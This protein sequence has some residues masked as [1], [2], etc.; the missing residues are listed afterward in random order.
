MRRIPLRLLSVG[1]ALPALLLA[2]CGSSSSASKSSSSSSPSSSTA[3]TPKTV[4]ASAVTPMSDISVNTAKPKAPAIKLAKQPFQVNKTTVKTLTKGTGRQVTTKD[5][6]YVDYVAVNGKNG[7]QLVNSFSAK[8][9]PV[10]LADK[11]QFPG[12]VTALKGAT[13]GSTMEVAIPPADGFGGAGNKQLGITNADT[14][15]FYMKVEDARAPLTQA[16][17]TKVAPKAGLPTVSVPN[18]E[19][20]AASITIPKGKKAPTSLIAQDL[21]TGNGRKVTKGDTITVSYTGVIWKTGKVFDSTAKEGGKPATFAIGV[22]Q[23]IP[24]WDTGLVGKTVGS[25]VLLVIPPKEGYGKNTPSGG[26][27]QTTDTLVF[28]VDIL[29]IG[30]TAPTAAAG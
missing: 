21:I 22:G 16:S 28:S 15:V 20:K 10:P 12:L 18:G 7:K 30:E 24:G 23:V 29:A 6:A 8:E 25:R 26:P 11:G 2:G 13:I 27:I 5:I 9:V 17:G 14:L 19:G 1:V 3:A 4:A